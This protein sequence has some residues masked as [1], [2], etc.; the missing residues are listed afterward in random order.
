MSTACPPTVCASITSH[1]MSAPAG[2]G[3]GSSND[4]LSKLTPLARR[5]VE[6]VCIYR[7]RGRQGVHFFK[8]ISCSFLQKNRLAHPLWELAQTLRKI[9]GPPLVWAQKSLRAKLT[10]PPLNMM[11]ILSL[12]NQAQLSS[13]H[14]A[15]CY[16]YLH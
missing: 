12:D 14:F 7:S 1:Q 3:G 5:K 2:R 6:C 9:L 13:F 11:W 16:V 10:Q 8:K 15:Y 4:S